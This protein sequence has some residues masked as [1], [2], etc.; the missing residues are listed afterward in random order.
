MRG[1][2]W[3][4]VITNT[5]LI[6][7][8][9]LVNY[10]YYYKVDPEFPIDDWK[11][12]RVDTLRKE[13]MRMETVSDRQANVSDAFEGL[14]NFLNLVALVALLLG[15][16]GVASSVFI[17]VKSKV[18]SIAI[19]RCLGLQRWDAFLIFFIQIGILGIT[20]VLIGVILGSFIQVILPEVLSDFL[21]FDVSFDI[22]WKAVFEGF[23]IGVSM[24][25]LFSLLP[26]L[27]AKNI[28]PLGILRSV[29]TP[30]LKACAVALLQLF[31]SS[32]LY[33]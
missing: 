6:Q 33:G 21:P 29:E 11:E 31:P 1:V 13:S 25:L 22:S 16:I 24:T 8:G 23:M 19:F 17:Y 26:L 4:A 28:S 32:C 12:E 18:S 7:P 30:S 3:S 14:Y 2:R 27:A 20:S 15:C 10:S 5:G 9:S